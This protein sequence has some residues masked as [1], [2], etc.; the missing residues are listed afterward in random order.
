M[1][2][3]FFFLIWGM[4]IASLASP[5]GYAVDSGGSVGTVDLNTGAFH[6]LGCVPG[7]CSSASI[8]GGGIAIGPSGGLYI[9]DD[10][11]TSLYR[12]NAVNGSSTLVGNSGFN[13]A[14]F[15]GL[16]DGRLFGIDLNNDLYR[17]NSTTGVAT[18]ITHLFNSSPD[19]IIGT[20]L[21]GDGTN[22]Y[23]SYEAPPFAAI[24]QL[25]T[26][27][28]INPNTGA[29]TRLGLTIDG[30]AGSAFIGGSLYAFRSACADDGMGGFTCNQD[31]IYR[32]NTTTGA[33][34]LVSTANSGLPIY[35][36]VATPEPAAWTMCALGL[37]CLVP[38]TRRRR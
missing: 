15:A 14:V 33:A 17:V 1:T 10:P 8:G 3:T 11:T 6:K 2:K 31:S 13:F 38:I 22:L 28:R 23:Y 25:S 12:F 30:L 21:A 36:A 5:F 34:T 16:G 9:Y 29:L 19:G 35:G 20:S 37:L 7:P 32:L 24:P 27:Y 18:L 26:L 4:Q